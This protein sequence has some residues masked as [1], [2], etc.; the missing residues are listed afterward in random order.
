MG[1]TKSVSMLRIAVRTRFPGDTANPKQQS[2]T[3]DGRSIAF[4]GFS[5]A[6]PGELSGKGT[7]SRELPC[8]IQLRT[9]LSWLQLY[10]QRPS[11]A[12]ARSVTT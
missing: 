4:F 11:N 5:E 6:R 2:N 3:Y 1:S 10:R 12:H 8:M 9:E 7:G